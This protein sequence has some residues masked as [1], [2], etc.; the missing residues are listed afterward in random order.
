MHP[1]R[2][3][4]F[5][6]DQ[7]KPEGSPCCS[8]RG[9]AAVI[10]ALRREVATRGLSES[11]AVTTCGSLGMCENGPN[12]VVY[13]EGIWYSH[14]SPQDVPEIVTEHLQKGHPVGRLLRTDEGALKAEIRSEPGQSRGHAQGARG[15]RHRSR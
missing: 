14:V 8:A 6:C 5:V 4:V 13:P 10:E 7:R 3:H 1:F 15:V 9:S 2:H 11:V 12:L